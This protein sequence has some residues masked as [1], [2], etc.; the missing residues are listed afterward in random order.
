M[1]HF[2]H[3]KADAIMA[4]LAK[5]QITALYHFTSIENLSYICEKQ[6]LCSKQIQE[7]EGLWPPPMPGGN[8]L[9]HYLDRHNGNWDRVS[10]S[11]TPFT[12]MAYHKKREDHLCF[13]TVKPEVATWLNVLFTDSNAAGTTMQRRGGG[14]E[15]MDLIK[16]EAIRARPRP[17]DREGWVRPVQAEVLVPDSIPFSHITQIGFVSRAS[18]LHAERLCISLQHPPFIIEEQLFTDS[19]QSPAGT[20]GFSFVDRLALSDTKID[21]NMLYLN[22]SQKNIYSKK[23]LRS[24]Y[25]PMAVR[26]VVGTHAS[27]YLHPINR[28]KVTSDCIENIEFSRAGQYFVQPGIELDSLTVS[29]YLIEIFL[30]KICRASVAFELQP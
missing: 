22:H 2:P 27:I 19:P 25:V 13:F 9:S 28:L 29:K 26:A 12:P 21:R 20:I 10:L 17:W 24:V 14:L 11:F 5:E 7:S 16:F 1:I 18:L 3:P 15:G 4:R 8:A 30:D 23:L 6:A